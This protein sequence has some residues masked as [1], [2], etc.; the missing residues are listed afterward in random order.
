MGRTEIEF[1]PSTP[2]LERYLRPHVLD[3]LVAARFFSY[4]LLDIYFTLGVVTCNPLEMHYGHRV[5]VPP[6]IRFS[7]STTPWPPGDGAQ[8]K[9]QLHSTRDPG[10]SIFSPTGWRRHF[11][12][13]I[14][15]LL[16]NARLKA[17]SES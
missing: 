7:L 16:L 3:E 10:R 17:A 1:P 9:V 6:S 14:P 13:D 12:G 11:D 15:Y 2:T 5:S 4:Q 8:P